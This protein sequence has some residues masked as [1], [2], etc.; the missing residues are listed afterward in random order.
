[1]IKDLFVQTKEEYKLVWEL[2][3]IR[4]NEY[5]IRYCIMKQCIKKRELEHFENRLKDIDNQLST[6]D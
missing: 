3:K 1:M 6:S 4:V 5:T 2:F